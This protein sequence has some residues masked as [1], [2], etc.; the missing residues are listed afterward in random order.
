MLRTEVIDKISQTLPGHH[1]N[2]GVRNEVGSAGIDR[3]G[4]DIGERMWECVRRGPGH[5]K[6]KVNWYA[7]SFGTMDV[8]KTWRVRND[9]VG[10]EWF[11]AGIRVDEET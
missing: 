6:C 8:S 1:V 11:D 2:E 3:G 10:D 9:G 4:I 7:K 5:G